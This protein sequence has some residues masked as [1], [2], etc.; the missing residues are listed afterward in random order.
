MDNL[1]VDGLVIGGGIAGMQAGNID[2]LLLRAPIAGFLLFKIEL[3]GIDYFSIG[4]EVGYV[5]TKIEPNG[6]VGIVSGVGGDQLTGYLFSEF[7]F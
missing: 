2:A 5:D 4:A 7:D 1:R 3:G 6:S